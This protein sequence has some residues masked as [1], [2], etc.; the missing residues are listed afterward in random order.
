MTHRHQ[1]RGRQAVLRAQCARHALLVGVA[2]VS[3]CVMCKPMTAVLD[4]PGGPAPENLCALTGGACSQ[5]KR[6]TIVN[7]SR[8][9]Q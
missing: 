9:L 8:S 1:A 5:R 2:G 7:R 3:F 6:L 4:R